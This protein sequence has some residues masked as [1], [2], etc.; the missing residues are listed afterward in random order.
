MN[1]LKQAV[2]EYEKKLIVEAIEASG[3][4]VLAAAESLGLSKT[5]LYRKMTALGIPV[6]FWKKDR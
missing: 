2:N 1:K 3:K 5:A 4:N 6:P